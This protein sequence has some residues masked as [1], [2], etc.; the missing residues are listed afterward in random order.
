VRKVKLKIQL[1][2]RPSLTCYAFFSLLFNLRTETNMES[3]VDPND[4]TIPPRGLPLAIIVI[5]GV[6]LVL[7]L[8]TVA[9]RVHTRLMGRV[10]GLDDGIMAAG[11]VSEFHGPISAVAC[12]TFL[13]ALY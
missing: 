6:F 8:F 4:R 2:L 7:S 12:S 13:G 3:L 5:S 10:F 1:L 11:T 9:I